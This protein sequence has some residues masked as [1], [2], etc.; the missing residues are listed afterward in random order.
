MGGER[1]GAMEQ[2]VGGAVIAGAQTSES[3]VRR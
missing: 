1:L 2:G 3:Q